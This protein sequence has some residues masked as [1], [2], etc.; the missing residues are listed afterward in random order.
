MKK[1]EMA[2]RLREER[3]KRKLSQKQ[4]SD[5]LKINQSTLSMYEC[6]LRIP[7][8]AIMDKLAKYYGVSVE[9]LFFNDKMSEGESKK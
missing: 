5:D 3:K 8:Y 2:K 9:T 6:G 4:V 1:E 7:Q